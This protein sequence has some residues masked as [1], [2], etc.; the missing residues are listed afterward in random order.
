MQYVE[1][2]QVIT[3]SATDSAHNNCWQNGILIF[4]IAKKTT[5]GHKVY[6]FK[7]IT[8]Y[9]SHLAMT[10]IIMNVIELFMFWLWQD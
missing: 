8:A 5:S 10:P 6:N 1:T 3:N 4:S 9:S 2:V 7:F